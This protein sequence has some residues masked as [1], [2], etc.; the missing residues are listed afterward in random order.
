MTHLSLGV[1][2]SESLLANVLVQ[3]YRATLYRVDAPEPFVLRV[4]E[5]SPELAA[6]LT[7]HRSSSALFITAWNPYSEPHSQADNEVGQRALKSAFAE[8][9][10]APVFLGTGVDP[11]GA[12][13]GEESFL[14]LSADFECA[15]RLALKFKQNAFL[16]AGHDPIPRLVLTR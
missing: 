10:L 2:P 3:A 6:L 5:H 11:E 1:P 8:E 4:D 9:N 13:P 16:W 7:A 12:W 15:H 14:V